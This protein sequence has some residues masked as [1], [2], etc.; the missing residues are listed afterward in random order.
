MSKER[1]K[2]NAVG[3]QRQ[4]EILKAKE[5]RAVFMEEMAFEFG[6]DDRE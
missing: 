3:L 5:T 4:E 2:E 6:A 1:H